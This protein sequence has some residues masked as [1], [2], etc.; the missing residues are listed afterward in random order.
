MARWL[1]VHIGGR[2]ARCVSP[3]ED[4]LLGT[5]LVSSLS[6]PSRPDACARRS[7]RQSVSPALGC[8]TL[9]ALPSATADGSTLFAKNSDR[10]AMEC[11]PLVQVPPGRHRPSSQ[12]RCQYISIPQVRETH[13]FIGSQPSWLWGLEHGVNDCR[14]AIGNE[15]VFSR[16]PPGAEALLGMD[17]VRLGLER[18]ETAR[19]ALEVMTGLLETHGQ[20]GPAVMGTTAGY[21]NSFLIADPAEAWILE[22]SGKQ[23]AARPVEGVGSISN[24]LIIEDEWSLASRDLTEYAVE[25]GWWSAGGGRIRFASA[26][27]DTEVMPG[28]VSEGRFARGCVL[29]REDAGHLTPQDMM[30]FLRNHGESGTILPEQRDPESA[31][32][33]TLCLHADPVG[34]TTASMVARLR[35]HWDGLPDLWAS[36]ATPCTGVF[37]PLYLEGDVPAAHALGGADPDRASPWWRFK[38]LQDAILGRPR[39]DLVR[40]QHYWG[41]WEQELVSR[42]ERLA[43]EVRAFQ[44]LGD[45]EA[46]RRL[47]SRFMEDNLTETLRRLD[48]WEAEEGASTG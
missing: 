32:F 35:P 45:G 11:Q 41:E 37:L 16:E 5:R 1:R 25:R 9:V 14:V 43:E 46:I 38:A 30:R 8:D 18:S 2:C 40:L 6:F 22:T 4:G 3:V 28:R 44:R 26:Y 15:A 47:T 39:S 34:T 31:D 17:L 20:G 10:L 48:A 29:L 23:W 27:R 21:H 7:A 12:V 36:L 24:H 42:S 13:G 33:F 19:Q